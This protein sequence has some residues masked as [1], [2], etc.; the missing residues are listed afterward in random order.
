MGGNVLL[1]KSESANSLPGKYL[2][3][4]LQNGQDVMMRR[5]MLLRSQRRGRCRMSRM[6]ACGCR[7][8]KSSYSS[9]YAIQR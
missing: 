7:V 1:F 3:A 9:L 5:P 6:S 8:L 4:M 2:P